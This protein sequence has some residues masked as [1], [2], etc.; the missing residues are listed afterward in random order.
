[1]R[2][3]RFAVAGLAAAASC[4]GG[5][6]PAN[7]FFPLDMVPGILGAPF[8]VNPYYRP[9]RH[10]PNAQHAPARPTPEPAVSGGTRDT[11]MAG[12]WEFSSELVTTPQDGG[13]M[14]SVRSS[15]ISAAS[16]VPV[17]LAP[18]CKLDR[19]EHDGAR[20]LWSMTCTNPQSTVRSDG[21]ANYHGSTMEATL[22]SH[23][24]GANGAP[25]DFTR[26]ITGRYLGACTPPPALA[27]TQPASSAPASA[28]S[29][30]VE[31][32]ALS[33][34]GTVPSVPDASSADMGRGA[35]R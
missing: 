1:M 34:R 31:P 5:P 25:S 23:L 8:R 26:R 20:V 6:Q 30:W 3:A 22:V 4:F 10:Y 2:W 16:A 13:S 27:A 18:Q 15:C 21:S 32:P 33:R 9:H 19:V 14:Q 12:R 17:E 29:D 28:A 24:P 7:A 35:G 11:V